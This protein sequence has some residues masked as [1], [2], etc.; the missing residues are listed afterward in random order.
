M[1][2]PC[3][4]AKREMELLA[5]NTTRWTFDKKYQWC[6]ALRTHSK[7][8]FEAIEHDRSVSDD[9][10][11]ELEFVELFGAL[12][13]PTPFWVTTFEYRMRDTFHFD[14]PWRPSNKKHMTRKKTARRKSTRTIQPKEE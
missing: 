3:R 5:D 7:L 13:L 4:A 14:F 2:A 6:K 9:T 12:L 10:K 8:H 11:E 1:S